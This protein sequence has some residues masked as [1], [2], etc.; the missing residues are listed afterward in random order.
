MQNRSHFE[1]ISKVVD[2]NVLLLCEVAFVK[3]WLKF[4]KFFLKNWNF[5]DFW[6]LQTPSPASI[7]S[8]RVYMDPVVTGQGP[9]EK[10]REKSYGKLLKA[11]TVGGTNPETP[12][13]IKLLIWT[14]F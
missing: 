6:L 2:E 13:P 10:W 14:D 3:I 11:A 8:H 4:G 1:R 7:I 5:L 12:R 9:E